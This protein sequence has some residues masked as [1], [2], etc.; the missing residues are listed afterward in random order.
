[1]S[2]KHV[3]NR[4]LKQGKNDCIMSG[5]FSPPVKRSLITLSGFV[6]LFVLYHLPELFQNYYQ[7]PLIWLL[8]TGMLLFVL[9]AYIIGKRKH[10][11]GYKTYGLFAFG[12]HWR[13]LAEGLVIGVSITILANMVPVWLLW[14]KISIHLDWEQILFQSLLFSIGT[15][16]PSLAED[17]LT[18]GYLMA[19]WPEKW[20]RKLLILFSAGVYVLNHIFRLNKPDVMLYLFLLGLLLMWAFVATRSLWLTLGIHWGGNIAYQFYA[21]AVSYE[22][23]KETGMENYVLAACYAIGFILVFLLFKLRFFS[24]ERSRESL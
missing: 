3:S 21:N 20:D 1:M 17:I 15:F 12:K 6:I 24:I 13:N 11:N 23:I 2:W 16:L 4:I 5:F 18:R 19:Y 22:T 14:N 8:E 7:K 9:F 10:K